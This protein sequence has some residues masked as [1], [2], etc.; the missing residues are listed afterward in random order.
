[1]RFWMLTGL[2][3]ALSSALAAQ[4]VI[5]DPPKPPAPEVFDPAIDPPNMMPGIYYMADPTKT[6]SGQR[7]K[8]EIGSIDEKYRIKLR[9]QFDPTGSPIANKATLSGLSSRFKIPAG[10]P[11]FL[12]YTANESINRRAMDDSQFLGPAR[13]PIANPSEIVLVRLDAKGGNRV[14]WL[15]F[16]N[17]EGDSSK[18]SK[19]KRVWL[20]SEFIH[21]RLF[22]VTPREPLTKGEYAFFAIA[23]SGSTDVGDQTVSN[24]VYAFSVE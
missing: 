7:I 20:L 9:I 8:H 1:M 16:L 23:K 6:E 12:F 4:V 10:T 15:G 13:L 2:G 21:P 5:I 22:K 17:R 24:R 11:R 3:L 18:P 19:K 14:A